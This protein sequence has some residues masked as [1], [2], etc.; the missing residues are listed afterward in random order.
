MTDADRPVAAAEPAIA[1]GALAR[2][3]IMLFAAQVVGNAGLFVALL[4]LARALGPSGRGTMAFMMVAAMILARLSMLGIDEATTVFAAQRPAER[5]ALLAN[6]VLFGL[7]VPPIVAG[8][9]AVVLWSSGLAPDGVGGAELVVVVLAATATGLALSGFAYLVGLSRFGR[10]AA[11]TAVQ[12]WLYAAVVALVWALSGM[13]VLLASSLWTVAQACW[14]VAVLY[15]GWR[16]A[17]ITR[18]RWQLLQESIA[19]GVRA[20][21]GSLFRFLNSRVDQILVVFLASEATLGRYAVAVNVFE[22][23]LYLP[24]AAAT[25]LLPV[26][27][28]ASV[29]ERASRVLGT[30]R[31][32]AL[33][34][35]VGVVVAAVIGPVLLPLLFGEDFQGSVPPFLLMLPGALGFTALII[36]VNALVASSAPGL[37]SIAALAA[38]VSGLALDVALIPPLGA[39]GAAIAGSVAYLV[40]GACA[41]AAFRR[42][43]PF[44]LAGLI[45]TRADA[46]KLT[47]LVEPLRSLRR[48]R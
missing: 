13:T 3:S 28:R 37:G 36:F 39:S 17:R 1:G 38:L 32:V 44:S 15:L 5:A 4:L 43:H 33:V 20:W 6:L 24:A 19:F 23:V 14:A 7:T 30:F 45:P 42:G 10:L 46:T 16:A 25:A 8:A 22:I 41:V 29:D 18:P 40:G 2:D 26:V 21:A 11:V 48:S 31:A 35:T 9:A 27:S 12:P 34:T 47:L